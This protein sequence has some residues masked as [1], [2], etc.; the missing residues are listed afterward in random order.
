MKL[1]WNL[2]FPVDESLLSLMKSAADQAPLAEGIPYPCFATVRICDD[3]SIR[4]LNRDYRGL[5]QSTDVLSFPSVR[6][7]EGRTAGDVPERL[8]RE[9]DEMMNACFLGDVVISMDHV[10]A[11]AAAYGHSE[12]REAAYLL[13]HSLCHLMGYDH[14]EDG[15]KAVMRAKEEEILSAVGLT[16]TGLN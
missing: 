9:Y 11:Q 14:M 6:W 8:K 5:D 16:R 7:P 13:V 3:E 12:A 4:A 10:R 1:E 15:E 2:D